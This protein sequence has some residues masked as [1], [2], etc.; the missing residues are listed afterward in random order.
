MVFRETSEFIIIGL[1]GRTGSGCTTAAGLLSAEVPFV[2]ASSSIYASKNDCLKF[3]ITSEYVKKNWKPFVRIQMRDIITGVLLEQ[4]FL[5]FKELVSEILKDDVAEISKKIHDFEDRYTKAHNDITQYKCMPDST[6]DEKELKKNKAWEIYFD[7]LPKFSAELKNILQ[8]RLGAY[9][10]LY[11]QIGDNIRASGNAKI[12][13]FDP[14]KIFTISKI[15]NKLIK[16]IRSKR[17]DGA[18]VVID[19]IRNPFEATYFHQRYSNFFL[20]S[21]NTPNDARL[22][23]LRGS[24]KFSEDQIRSLDDKEYPERLSGKDNFISQNIQKCIELSDIHIT[25]PHREPYDHN[26]LSSQLLWYVSLILHPGLVPPTSIERGMQIAYSAKLN[27]GCISR[28]VGAVI[29]DENYSIKA[30]GWNNTP[31]GQTPCVL[32]NARSILNGG[33]KSTYSAYERTDKKFHEVMVSTFTD[34]VTKSDVLKGRNVSYCFKEIQNKIDGEKNQV[35]TRSLHAEENAFL[36][37]AKYGGQGIKNGIL[38]TTAS[39]CE[40]CSKKAYQL[41]IKEIIFIDP[42]PGISERHILNVGSSLPNLVLFRGAI[43]RA[44]HR[45]YQPLLA[46]K[47]ELKMLTGYVVNDGKPEVNKDAEIRDLKEKVKILETELVCYKKIG[48]V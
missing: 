10:S 17:P 43:G 46:Y 35:H 11:Q 47:D 22:G 23:H 39:P 21:I 36:Q 40:L 5:D 16:V 3:R 38:F 2:P 8:S 27:S 48:E 45:L 1:T 28:Q 18:F 37:I 24:H 20:V 15:A 14:E 12:N 34:V 26:D 6:K 7:F 9:T 4:N 44:Y 31:E 42:Y 32:R 29:T 30:V 13:N 19:A 25:N 33:E 41:G